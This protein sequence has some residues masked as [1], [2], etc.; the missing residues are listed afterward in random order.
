MKDPLSF[1]L[2]SG[3]P[4]TVWLDCEDISD[5]P[6]YFWID[7]DRQMTDED[8]REIIE[9]NTYRCTSPYDCSGQQ[10]TRSLTAHRTPAGV[11]FIHRTGFDY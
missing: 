3:E 1:S 7:P 4:R 6:T 5:G 10:Y 8:I 11:A 9:D 2:L